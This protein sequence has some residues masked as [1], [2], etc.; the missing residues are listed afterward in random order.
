MPSRSQVVICDILLRLRPV[1]SGWFELAYSGA[2]TAQRSQLYM[3]Y[4]HVTTPAKPLRRRQS[5]CC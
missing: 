5:R 4:R 1:R 2:A 3:T